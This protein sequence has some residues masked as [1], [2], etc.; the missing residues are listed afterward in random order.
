MCG[1]EMTTSV[2]FWGKHDEMAG[3]EQRESVLQVFIIGHACMVDIDF[4]I[5]LPYFQQ[6]RCI[7][8]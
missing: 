1:F 3:T 6:P 4:S 2:R 7:Y 5:L 8:A